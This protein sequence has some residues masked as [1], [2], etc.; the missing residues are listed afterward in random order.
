MTKNRRPR[1]HRFFPVLILVGGK[2]TGVSKTVS[3]GRVRGLPFLKNAV[4]GS[5]L[6]LTLTALP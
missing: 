4:L 5:G 6:T 2:G 1:Q 3:R